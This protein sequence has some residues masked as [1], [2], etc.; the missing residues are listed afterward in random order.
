MGDNWLILD[1]SDEKFL[2]TFNPPVAQNPPMSSE[3]DELVQAGYDVCVS[4]V[5]LP[6][7][8]PLTWLRSALP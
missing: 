7:I 5:L 8:C 3:L 1:V 6:W 4:F 2:S